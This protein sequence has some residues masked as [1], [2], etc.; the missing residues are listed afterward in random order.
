MKS[1]NIENALLAQYE[2][3]V[4]DGIRLMEEKVLQAYENGK[5][6]EIDG[7]VWF[8]KS[9]LDNLRDI[10]TDLENE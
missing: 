6:V 3:G 5:P 1:Y 8:I 4:R 9:D 2:K 10:F 7:R